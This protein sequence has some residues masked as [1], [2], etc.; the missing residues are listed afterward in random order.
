[1]MPIMATLAA[2]PGDVLAV[3]TSSSLTSDLIRVGEAVRGLPAVANHVAI[4]THQDQRGDGSG[5]RADRAVSAWLTAHTGSVT[6][7]PGPTTPSPSRTIT[8]S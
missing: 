3:W 8:I 1:M 2:A 7:G 6:A 5:S 4:I